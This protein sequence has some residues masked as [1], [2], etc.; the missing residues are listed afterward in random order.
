MKQRA[1]T[2]VRGSFLRTTGRVLCA[3]LVLS[4]LPALPVGAAPARSAT[5][6]GATRQFKWHDGPRTTTG[7]QCAVTNPACSHDDTLIK[8]TRPGGRLKIRAVAKEDLP[9]GVRYR[10]D[11]D[12][13]LY[14]SN[15]NGDVGKRVARSETVAPIETVQINRARA[16]YYLVRVLYYSGAQMSYDGRA[17][18]TPRDRRRG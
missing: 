8:L 14:R 4:A 18:W 1:V 9:D 15:A 7:L 11:I 16:G 12:I 13:Y 17:T 3:V 10:P 6:N 2:H 5:L